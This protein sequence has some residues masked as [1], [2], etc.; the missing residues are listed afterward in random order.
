M[1]WNQEAKRCRRHAVY[2]LI[3]SRASQYW[4]RNSPQGSGKDAA[5]F[6]RG[7]E[8]P[9][10]NPRPMREAEDP[11]GIGA[12]FSLVSF[13]WPSK[14]K[15]LGC[16]SENRHQNGLRGALLIESPLRTRAFLF[17]RE[18]WQNQRFYDS[19]ESYLGSSSSLFELV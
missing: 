9:S 15:K 18:K 13:F 11:G 6:R 5:R 8:A 19:S 4:A 17:S 12:A 7:W 10:E 1:Q 3:P 2:P 16:R 14:R